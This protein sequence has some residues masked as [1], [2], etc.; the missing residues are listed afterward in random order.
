MMARKSPAQQ[1]QSARLAAVWGYIRNRVCAIAYLSQ[2]RIV[3]GSGNIIGSS[4]GTHICTARH[5]A[6]GFLDSGDAQIAFFGGNSLRRHEVQAF[7]HSHERFDISLLK[8]QSPRQHYYDT[9]LITPCSR[10]TPRDELVL[11][12]APAQWVQ[13]NASQQ[14]VTGLLFYTNIFRGSSSIAKLRH[15][16]RLHYPKAASEVRMFPPSGGLPQAPGMSG[17]FVLNFPPPEEGR[18]WTPE[19]LRILGVQVE[20]LEHEYLIATKSQALIDLLRRHRIS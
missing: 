6:E 20:W 11:Y 1:E 4:T 5:V 14:D 10:L 8:L 16:I 15:Q 12:G 3:I 2:G 13:S 19:S 17:A 18:I 9:G 7:A